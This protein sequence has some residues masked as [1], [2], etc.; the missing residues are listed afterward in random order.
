MAQLIHFKRNIVYKWI[1]CP[2]SGDIMEDPVIA[3]DGSVS[4]CNP[5][6]PCRSHVCMLQA[7]VFS[8]FSCACLARDACPTL[9]PC[10]RCCRRRCVCP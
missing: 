7:A 8:C 4:A 2:I 10:C 6:A 5:R 3:A 1:R 9:A